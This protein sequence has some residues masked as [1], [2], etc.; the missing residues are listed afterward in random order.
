MTASKPLVFLIVVAL[1]LAIQSQSAGNMS[2][3][4]VGFE[5]QFN[6]TNFLGVKFD[7]AFFKALFVY[8][9]SATEQE[10]SIL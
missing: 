3:T 8:N 6:K 2:V 7:S 1:V 4:D 10:I 9:K 5:Q